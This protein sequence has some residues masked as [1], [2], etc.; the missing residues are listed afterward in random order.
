MQCM[1][2]IPDANYVGFEIIMLFPLS[3][4]KL[5][6]IAHYAL[7]NLDS[8]SIMCSWIILKHYQSTNMI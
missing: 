4:M 5:P 1:D 7:E 6:I 2:V 8:P 3:I